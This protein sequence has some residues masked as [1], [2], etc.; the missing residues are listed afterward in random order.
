MLTSICDVYKRERETLESGRRAMG[1]YTTRDLELA[2]GLRKVKLRGTYVTITGV[3]TSLEAGFSQFVRKLSPYLIFS[4]SV[5]DTKFFLKV[6]EIP[7]DLAKLGMFVVLPAVGAGHVGQ[8]QR[9][10]C[11]RA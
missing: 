2:G 9:S 8:L 11:S 6:P 7:Q 4:S 10:T 3:R 1:T 5:V